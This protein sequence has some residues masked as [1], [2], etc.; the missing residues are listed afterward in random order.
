MAD[1]FI[2]SNVPGSLV[3]RY[4]GVRNWLAAITLAWGAVQLSMGYIHSW[5]LLVLCRVLLGAFEVGI[6]SKIDWTL[7]NSN[8]LGFIFSLYDPYYIH[9][10]SSRDFNVTAS[11]LEDPGTHAMKFRNGTTATS[12]FFAY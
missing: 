4:F 10:V 8:C 3:L 12:V 2:C 7:T 1:D 5:H 11:C 9:L 6:G